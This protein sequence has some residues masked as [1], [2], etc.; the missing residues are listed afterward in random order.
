MQPLFRTLTSNVYI[1]DYYNLT[2]NISHVIFI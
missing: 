2:Y 1:I